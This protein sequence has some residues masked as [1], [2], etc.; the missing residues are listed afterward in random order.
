MISKRILSNAVPVIIF[1]GC[2]LFIIIAN[3]WILET[4]F[5]L[6][7]KDEFKQLVFNESGTSLTA[8]PENSDCSHFKIQFAKMGT[9]P[10][11]AL[12]SYPGSGNSWTRYLLESGSGVFTGSIYQDPRIS[13]K[14]RG[15]LA[16]F[17]DGSTLVQKTHHRSI[18]TEKTD[19]YGLE[20]RK[21]HVQ[22]FIGG[23][24]LIIRNPF[25]AIMSHWNYAK[26]LSHTVVATDK[27][28]CTQDFQMFTFRSISRWLE[29]IEDWVIWSPNLLVVFYEDLV[30]NPIRELEK[31]IKYL[32][33]P[34]NPERINCLSPH[35]SGNFH[36]TG[37]VKVDPFTPDHQS[38]IG[39]AAE[40]ANST[41]ITKL[42]IALP[43]YSPPVFREKCA[44]KKNW[45]SSAK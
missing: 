29:L 2:F 14:L 36:R 38:L 43:S 13:S 28:F 39:W 18:F 10:P 27:T 35:V 21:A 24:V 37:Q 16:N 4:S 1:S 33:M 15:E 32:K 8:W 41:L 6:K 11:T 9:L 20:W 44:K 45:S 5:I 7:S 17:T 19:N 30:D 23:G 25:T 12:V 22:K 34:T 26:T 3:P 40:K 42:G 31:M